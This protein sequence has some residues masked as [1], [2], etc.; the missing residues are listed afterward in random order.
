MH[1]QSDSRSVESPKDI[2]RYL[3][4][5]NDQDH[6]QRA[7]NLLIFI[8]L[9]LNNNELILVNELVCSRDIEKH[10]YPLIKSIAL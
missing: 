5:F 6:D 4:S 10:A 8:L 2:R 1:N 3:A 9:I 7:N